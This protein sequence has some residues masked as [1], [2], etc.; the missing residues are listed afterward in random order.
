MVFRKIIPT[1]WKPE[2]AEDSIEGILIKAEPSG[3]YANKVYSLECK[4]GF[5]I[6]YGT[7]VLDDRMSYVKEG[8]IIR[9]VFKGL[10]KNKKGQDTKIFEVL[11]D[12]PEQPNTLAATA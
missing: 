12:E 9:I 7:T 1:V 2:N 6:V 11:K 4:T 5:F 8:D 10:Q 3:N